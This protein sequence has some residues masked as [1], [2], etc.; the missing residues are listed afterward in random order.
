MKI[1]MKTSMIFDAI[2]TCDH[3][4][5]REG[6]LRPEQKEVLDI[7][8]SK[9]E[10]V[11]TEGC[12]S[13]SNVCAVLFRCI[14]NI[15]SAT[16]DDLYSFFCSVNTKNA[17]ERDGIGFVNKDISRTAT[18]LSNGYADVY[19]KY[20]LALKSAGF[21][22]LWKEKIFPAEQK[23]I[24]RLRESFGN[25]N[26]D[27][28]LSAISELK[29]TAFD[30]DISVY[31][32]LMSYP[33][34]FRL[35]KNAFLDTINDHDEYFKKG[36]LS[37]IAHE[38][39]HGF[40]SA[41]LKDLYL[42][43]VRSNRYLTSTHKTL[44]HDMHSG[45]EEEFVMAAEYYI[46]YKCGLTSKEEIVERGLG[47]YAG[48]VPVSLYLFDIMIRNNETIRDLN[49][50]LTEAFKC[51]KLSPDD[52]I[53]AMDSFLPAPKEKESF[54]TCLFAILRRCAYVIRDVQIS[55]T[56]DIKEEI[57]HITKVHFIPNKSRTVSFANGC[58]ELGESC[59]LRETLNSTGLTVDRLEF[60]EK[61]AALALT[62]PCKGSNVAAFRLKYG[63]EVFKSPYT[64]N[65]AYRKSTPIQ[66][67]FSFVC[68]N[69]RYLITSKCPEHVVE[70]E[71]D[72][73]TYERFGEEI[74]KAT[75]RAEDIVMLLK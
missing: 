17:E 55:F 65:I 44:L 36:F 51:G 28:L 47:R 67:E 75:K 24:Q 15:E 58:E 53:P 11:F 46:M 33:V 1:I 66:A 14:P 59:I 3:L 30:K 62:F 12:L 69:S 50:Y 63:D 2:C 40:A 19:K 74:I 25:V 26:I 20:I 32:S 54:F 61:R 10:N 39:M 35:S 5:E 68:K 8:S 71:R 6:Y 60:T 52:V 13:Y 31:V 29:N 73:E 48:C 70:L 4:C 16:L 43:F 23:Q 21:E 49:L 56:E 64:V 9:T 42:S 45:N 57:E 37:M 72:E 34:S 18:V 7:L 27:N 41:E 22:E 38:L